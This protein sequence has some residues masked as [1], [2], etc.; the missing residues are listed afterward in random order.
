MYTVF[1]ALC[2]FVCQMNMILW[3]LNGVE[4]LTQ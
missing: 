1:L 4:W 2:A 3:S